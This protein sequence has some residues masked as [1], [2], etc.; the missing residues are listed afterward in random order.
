MK[1]LILVLS[2]NQSPYDLL[3]RSQQ[4][5][6]DSVVKQDV[7]TVYYYGGC[8]RLNF[9]MTQQHHK[10]TSH[11]LQLPCT[12]QYYYMAH[13]FKLALTHLKDFDYDIIFR[14]NSSSYINKENLQKIAL[15]F[16]LEKLYA[17]WTFTDSNDFGGMCVS[18]AGIWLS[19]D[20]AEIL[21]NEIDP[22]FEMEEDVYCGRI[23]RKH[24][25]VAIDDRSRVDW[26][27][28]NWK[29]I[30]NAYHIRFKTDDRAQDA[31]NMIEVHQKIIS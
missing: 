25:I 16:P 26:P 4:Q 15:T 23:L 8:D 3:M 9:K 10:T 7:D 13:K 2:Y 17:G 14:T 11:E 28:Q 21:M 1:I 12:D 22:S 18:G 24:G 19:R 20:T 31:K 30:T 5:T 6:W 27:Q 29:N